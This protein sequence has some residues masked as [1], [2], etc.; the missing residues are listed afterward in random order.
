MATATLQN[1][2]VSS[3]VNSFYANQMIN[4][5]ARRDPK[6]IGDQFEAMF[7]RMLLQ[8]SR[9]DEE[10]EQDSYF[11]GSGTSKSE[12]MFHNE[13]AN[14]M[15]SSGQLGISDMMAKEAEKAMKA[16]PAPG[17]IKSLG[18]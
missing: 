3:G 8:E 4:N 14:V 6:Q 10:E 16:H 11:G 1:Y 17:M 2:P 7:Y 13:L 15:A 18:M 9:V 5:S 12:E